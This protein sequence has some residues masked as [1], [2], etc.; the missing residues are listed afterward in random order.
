[1]SISKELLSEVLGCKLDI[2]EQLQPNDIEYIEKVGSKLYYRY[3]NIYE[4]MHLCK[5]WA[6]TKNYFLFSGYGAISASCEVNHRTASL[7]KINP[8]EIVLA[9][10][11][12]EACFLACEW[13]LENKDN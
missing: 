5:E 6:Y 3:I 8:Q 2:D 11:E 10:T 7:G 4:L 1:M 13:I 12:P 9:D